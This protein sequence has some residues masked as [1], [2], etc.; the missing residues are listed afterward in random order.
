VQAAQGKQKYDL[1]KWKYCELR[2]TIN[3]SCDIELLEVS[4]PMSNLKKLGSISLGHSFGK[5]P[6]CLAFLLDYFAPNIPYI[7]GDF[8]TFVVQR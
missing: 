3:T 1:S 6:T 8:H 2:D 4:R 5:L 7:K